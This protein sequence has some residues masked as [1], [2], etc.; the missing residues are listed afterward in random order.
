MSCTCTYECCS[1]GAFDLTILDKTAIEIGCLVIRELATNRHTSG[2]IE[3]VSVF[4]ESQ[5]RRLMTRRPRT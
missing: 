4:K 3:A 5:I 2:V 1:K